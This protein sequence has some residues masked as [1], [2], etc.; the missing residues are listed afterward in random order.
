MKTLPTAL[1]QEKNKLATG[2]AW[3]M[4]L[5]ITLAT[6]VKMYFCSNNEDVT[7]GGQVYTAFPFVIEPT[8][9]NSKG[10]IPTI[11]LRVS[12]VTQLIQSYVEQYDGGVESEVLV[13]VVNS[14]YLNENYSELE[15]VFSVMST[16]SEA[17]WISFDL[18]VPS[19]M[20]RR[21][22]PCRF[23]ALHC[24]WNFKSV[25][26]GYAGI[27]T[28]CDRSLDRCQVLDNEARFGGYPGLQRAGWKMV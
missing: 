25:E 17:D 19:P 1:V 5:D 23:I 18:G 2:S 8:K 26:C 10:E 21:F 27:A 13:R 28:Q 20:R 24:N 9:L 15:M 22:P 14:A 11:T 4:L 7:F 6:D 3:I 16:T 12:N